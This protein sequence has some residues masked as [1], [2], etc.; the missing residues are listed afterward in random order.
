MKVPEFYF[1]EWLREVERAI[2]EAIA[3][4]LPRDW[5]ESNAT[6]SWMRALRRKFPSVRIRDL[7]F[8]YAVAWD[9]LRLK[10]KAETSFGDVGVFV[11]MRY[12]NGVQLKGVSF[13]EAKRIYPSGR[14]DR[15]DPQQLKR[16]VKRTPFHRLGLYSQTAIND[17]ARGVGGEGWLPYA[18]LVVAEPCSNVLAAVVPTPIALAMNS[19]KPDDLHPPSLPLSYQLC[20]RYLRGY[21]L[22]FAPVLVNVVETAGA[23]TPSF[24]LVADVQIGGET[25]PPSTANMVPIGPD[26]PY[27]SISTTEDENAR[28]TRHFISRPAKNKVQRIKLTH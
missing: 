23:G 28:M 18:P 25:L 13:I 1:F 7:G 9:T 5:D 27:E 14:Y 11:R 21:H 6:I 20:T 16:M 22:D 2:S 4:L 24:L 19:N 12:P 3:E 10:G 8:P 26:T 17:A 15:L